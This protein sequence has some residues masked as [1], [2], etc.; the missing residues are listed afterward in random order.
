MPMIAAA[1]ASAF[2][3]VSSVAATVSAAVAASTV[4]S[5]AMTV[6]KVLSVA[7]SIYSL[8]RKP[9]SGMGSPSPVAFKADPNAPITF[10]AGVAAVGG[11]M[12]FGQTHAPKNRFLTYITALSH[13]GPVQSVQAGFTAG[14][15]IVTFGRDNGEGASGRY[16]DRMWQKFAVGA[17]G[18]AALAMTSTATKYTPARAGPLY[19]WTAQHKLSGLA[20]TMWT[21][22]SDTERL[23]NG[24]PKP[25]WIVHGGAVYDPRK[26]STYPGGAGPQRWNDRTTWSFEGNENPHLHA[27][28][29][30]IGHFYNGKKVGGAGIP[31]EQIDVASF[32]QGANV[33]DANNWRLSYP[34]T[35][36]MR[37][38]DVLTTMLQAG[39]ARPIAR[40]AKISCVT[41]TP[42]VSL[43]TIGEADLVGDFSV[44]GSQRVRDRINTVIPRC[45][46]PSLK[47]TVQ[48]FG[49]VTGAV[50]VAEDG[51]KVKPRE[52][53]YEGVKG[54]DGGVHVRQLAAYDL[55][56][57][58]EG[59]VATLPLTAKWL[60]LRAGDCITIDAPETLMNGQKVVIIK[61]D[62]DPATAIVT[63]TVQ[64]ETD[65][66]H[67]FALGQ[68]DAPPPTPALTGV[69]PL[70]LEPPA[71]DAWVV[72][73]R[74]TAGGGEPGSGGTAP[75]VIVRPG[76][77][78]QDGTYD[79]PSARAVLIRYRREGIDPATGV[80]YPFGAPQS[81]PPSAQTYELTG[82][83]AGLTYRLEIAYQARGITSDWTDYGT[84]TVPPLVATDT[85]A[86]AGRP[87][88]DLL[89][90]VDDLEETYGDTASA[91]AS[92]AAAAAARDAADLARNASQAA[93]A[94]SEAARDIAAAAASAASAASSAAATARDTATTAA[95]NAATAQGLAEAA[96]NAAQAANTAAAGARDDALAQAAAAAG[97]ASTAAGHATTATTKADEASGS[98]SAAA[99]SA[100]TATSAAGAAGGSASASA[101]SASAAAT[102]ATAAGT[103]ASAAE[104][105]RLAAQTARSGAESA[106]DASVSARD[107]ANGSAAA[108]ASSAS[109]AATSRDQAGGSASAAAGSAS[110]A[111]SSA[112]AAASSASAASS[113]AIE[114]NAAVIGAGR[115]NLLSRFDYVPVGSFGAE[116]LD[117]GPGV[118]GTWCIRLQPTASEP[119]YAQFSPT[120]IAPNTPY[121]IRAFV[122]ISAGSGQVWSDFQPDGLPD[123]P[124]ITVNSANL[125]TYEWSLTTPADGAMSGAD[126]RFIANPS[127]ATFV[128]YDLKIEVAANPSQYTASPR[129]GLGYANSSVQAASTATAQATL[130]GGSASAADSSRTAAETAR[131]AAQVSAANA[132]TSETNAAGSASTA[133]TAAGISTT[134]R[135]AALGSANAASSSASAAASSASAAGTSASAAETDRLA[136]QTARSGAEIARD[137]SVAARDDANGSA[138]AAASSAGLAAT[139]RDQAGAS[140]G[141]AA[142]SA[143]A[144]SSSAGAAASSAAAASSS[145]I[146]AN[147]TLIAQGRLNLL[148]RYDFRADYSTAGAVIIDTPSNTGT[149]GARLNRNGDFQWAGFTPLNFAPGAPYSLRTVVYSESAGSVYADV[150]GPGGTIAV[151]PSVAIAAG[152]SAVY[153]WS[154]FSI[155]SA[156]TYIRVIAQPGAGATSFL[157]P[158]LEQAT[159]PSAYSAS[160]RDG[161]GYAN[162]GVQAASTATAQATLAGERATAADSSRT[163]AET[164]RGAAQVAAS[165]AATSESNASGSASTASAASIVSASARDAA[166]GYRDQ[167]GGSA[168]AAA[169][170]A[171]TATTRRDEAGASATS[172]STSANTAT[173]AR[174]AAL[175]HRDNASNSA[176][177]A[178]SSASAASAS[179]A[180]AST[181]A[182]LSA[183]IGL[184]TMNANPVFSGYS[185]GRGSGVVNGGIPDGWFPWGSCKDQYR[186]PGRFSDWAFYQHN[187]YGATETCGITQSYAST[188]GLD[189]VGVGYYVLEADIRLA[190]GEIGGAGVL[191]YLA[192]GGSSATLDFSTD[193]P[194]GRVTNP[195][196]PATPVPAPL[197]ASFATA[198]TYSF[199]KLVKIESVGTSGGR[200]IFHL[201]TDWESFS[202]TRRPKIIIWDRC[203]I[204]PAT[205]MEVAAQKASADATAA[206]AQITAEAAT[207]ASQFSALA[208]KTDTL[209]VQVNT[210]PNLIEGFENGIPAGM[211]TS[212]GVGI[213]TLN[214]VW[215]A[216]LRIYP[217]GPGT[218]VVNF[219]KFD[220]YPNDSYQVTGDSLLFADAGQTC[221]F[222]FIAF[223]AG[224][225]VVGDSGQQYVNGQHDYSYDVQRRL[226]HLCSYVTP[227]GTASLQVRF[228]F[229]Y[230]GAGG[231]AIGIRQVKAERGFNNPSAFTAD[232]TTLALAAK[233][234]SQAGAIAGL[235]GR[236]LAYAQQE[237]FAGAGATAFVALRAETSPGVIT[238]DVGI[239]ARTISLYNNSGGD[240]RLAMRVEGGNALFTGGL[241]AGAFIR[242]GNGNGWPVALRQVD[243]SASDGEAVSFGTDLGSLPTLTLA[244]NNLAPLGAGETYDIRPVSLTATGFTLYAK[245]NVPGTPANFNRTTSY[246]TTAF[247]SGGLRI[248]KTGDANSSDGSYRIVAAGTNRHDTTG[249]GF[250]DVPGVD[251]YDFATG[252][253]QVWAKKGGVWSLVANL[254]PSSVVDRRGHTNGMPFTASGSWSIDET[255]T[256]G[257]AV[258]EVGLR[259]EA[260]GDGYSY[261]SAFYNLI[262]TAPGTASGVRSATPDGQKTRIT[263]RPQ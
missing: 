30:L 256:L 217:P 36:A 53:E 202:T 24:V 130:A 95:G 247:G 15:E 2:A 60:R 106:R 27:L 19:E 248:D 193:A 12:L 242:L 97:S 88:A 157:D 112:S 234:T 86:V 1:A 52:L 258:Q 220:A 87:A 74:V 89:V 144:A 133:N 41:N 127:T 206:I 226:D 141:A 164:A 215:G 125:A 152:S 44:T 136:A 10:V 81:F 28:T 64:S 54:D 229:G 11:N 51:G 225:G 167:A 5:T 67:A 37:K 62:F 114:A 137:S 163:A 104:T 233:V 25:L 188:N 185:D 222:D 126:F 131:S 118:T 98:A 85:T 159:G 190:A 68:T 203:D 173:A 224:G 228:V 57:L 221:Y 23:P 6:I 150:Q 35:T 205:D 260:N 192:D 71:P 72:E 251:D 45:R 40:G 39:G 161:L 7:S 208:T 153:D 49:K 16:Q 186:V 171:S 262:W 243:F 184:G 123:G 122:G 116:V 244:L 148:S 20:H 105:E 111:A 38:W 26:D 237:V 78:D 121:T 94:N 250:T 170:S 223:D 82:L 110:S 235:N 18:A 138:A 196:P 240:Y 113:S 218:H 209:S 241:Q 257:D 158:K 119:A 216:Q 56:A 181:S 178:A 254:Y 180:A 183:K 84:V 211:T 239:G 55:T 108:A 50:Y 139:S 204:R 200:G 100:V 101:A 219:A 21:M 245:I 155:P 210:R 176:S 61:R 213:A 156:A 231:T 46:L 227:A 13:G 3:A 31:P 29:F 34:W 103:A 160:P 236:T 232:K 142:G 147:A 134:A 66:K 90:Q 33:C 83:S 189:K 154:N 132:A 65:G 169:S 75:V 92:A 261:V 128:F 182:T 172:A 168:S 165:N 187:N 207:R 42:R 145:A 70:V 22:W 58:R 259:H 199:R 77:G 9:K 195:A 198:G 197:G 162:A 80:A 4:L 73:P 14:D 253:V 107:D 214:D 149:W 48:P 238:S 252:V 63:V 255:V 96:R 124:T 32:V 115:L 43:A 230:T 194:V 99:G 246:T 212:G 175:G 177:A 129:D 17:V 143:S 174:D 146:S 179:A 166:L 140:A 120:N 91:A 8:T 69:D 151:G 249:A 47:W 263:V 117:S 191:F 102:S 79:E 135:D 201:M 59:L 76:G 93:Q 109:L